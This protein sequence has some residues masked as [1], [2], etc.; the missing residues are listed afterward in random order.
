[1]HSIIA[2]VSCNVQNPDQSYDNDSTGDPS[3]RQCDP[4]PDGRTADSTRQWSR[5]ISFWLARYP[6]VLKP[7]E[8]AL[9]FYMAKDPQFNTRNMLDT[10]SGL[11]A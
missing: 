9:K 2:V 3:R 10:S 4:L 1:M 5:V 11:R 8:E 6:D 7:F